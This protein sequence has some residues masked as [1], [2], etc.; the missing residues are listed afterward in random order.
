MNT[1][2]VYHDLYLKC[3]IL[4]S[5]N[6]FKRFRSNSLKNYGLCPSH[7]LSAGLSWY[8]IL[9][10]KKI[11]LEFIPDPVM[12]IFFAKGTS[13]GTSYISDRCSKANH[14]CFKILY[15]KQESKHILC[16]DANN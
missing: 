11:K 1:V 3:D 6:V 2:K 16:L 12:Y 5:A 15:P 13:G 8:A 4:L 10:M 7:Y 14:K 9:K